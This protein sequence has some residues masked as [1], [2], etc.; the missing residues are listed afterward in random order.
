MPRDRRQGWVW[1]KMSGHVN[2]KNV[3]E[4]FND[5]KYCKQFAEALSIPAIQSAS[6][7]GLREESV[8]TVLG[9]SSRGK[10][11]LRLSCENGQ[12]FNFS[13]KKSLAGQVFLITIDHFILGFEKQFNVTIP[14]DVKTAIELFWGSHES[15]PDI[16]QSVGTSPE[17]E[18]RK[19]RLTACTLKEYDAKLYDSLL[20]WF[21]D[22]V[23]LLADFCFSKGL[24]SDERLWADYVWYIN[25]V[26]EN[27]VDRIIPIKEIISACEENKDL[28]C[29]GTMNNG[30]T[31]QLPFGFVQW[32]S[33]RRVIPGCIQFHHQYQ[34]LTNILKN[35][36]HL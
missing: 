18:L 28:V 34:A 20:N 13:I 29:Y 32:H 21:K 31:I 30:T 33:P 4:L 1:A 2:E 9:E 25:K 3:C 24:V 22:N 35:D 14:N 19:H 10:T 6:V 36:K 23:G 5:K 16:I 11:D 15:V 8:S 27:E 7:G 12:H 17:Y 26:G